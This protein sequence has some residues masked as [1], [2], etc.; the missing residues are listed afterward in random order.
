MPDLSHA[1]LTP[2]AKQ[3]HQCNEPDPCTIW[4]RSGEFMAGDLTWTDAQLLS[5]LDDPE[6]W[7]V[8]GNS[9]SV[10]TRSVTLRHALRQA[11]GLLAMGILPATV[12]KDSTDRVVV[13][14][15]QISRLWQRL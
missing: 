1:Y 14:A 11:R 3:V 12:V 2:P 6:L 9:G 8:R 7:L 4:M 5:H 15:D 13:P 10:L